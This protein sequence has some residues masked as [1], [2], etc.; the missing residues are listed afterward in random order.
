V[1]I[2]CWGMQRALAGALLWVGLGGAAVLLV[3]GVERSRMLTEGQPFGMW[4]LD[5]LER[6]P[7]LLREIVPLLIV[8]GVV[9]SQAMSRNRGEW[10][11]LQTTG[12]SPGRL[13]LAS[14][15]GG[16]LLA[17]VGSLLLEG[18][19]PPVENLL[20]CGNHAWIPLAWEPATP[21]SLL[22]WSTPLWSWVLVRRTL[23]RHDSAPSALV[24]TVLLLGSTQMLLLLM[25]HMEAGGAWCGAALCGA[26]SLG[27]ISRPTRNGPAF[28]RE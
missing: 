2:L 26:L 9:W 28:P 8:V 22:W 24:H 21:R 3:D 14:A 4:G 12:V 17:V 10:I 16:G 7:V 5:L 27:T 11:G 6:L 23:G 15:A 25:V 1:R 20:P 19:A 13:A 18:F